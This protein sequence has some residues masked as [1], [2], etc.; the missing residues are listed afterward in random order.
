MN[1]DVINQVIMLT[2]MMM[3]GVIL[4][5]IKI[6]TDEVNKGLSNILLNVTLPSM[7]LYSFNFNFSMDML[8]SAAM[9]FLYSTLIHIVLII[10]SKIFYYKFEVSKKNVYTFATVF[11]NCGFVG[12]PV[13]QGIFGN[14]GVFYTSIFTIPFNIF[15]YSYGIMLF[16]GER[17]LK[18]IKKNLINMPLTSIFIGTII[19]L[20]SIKLPTPVIKTLGS[21]GNMTTPMSMFIIGAM[22]ADVKLKDVFKDFSLYYVNFIKLIAAPLIIYFALRLLGADKT[23]LYICVILVSM[24][25]ASLIGVLAER[26]NVNK[27]IASKCAFLT[28]ILSLITIP[29]I[30][31]LMDML[32]K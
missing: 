5:K 14:A 8:K 17:D 22:L 12:Y 11:S 9:V 10:L 31:A 3:A 1:I 16:T 18:S 29:S 21:I 27:A 25:T 2:L 28:T 32:T 19:F 23:L 20:F 7:I 15:V 26:Y 6:I 30:I 4:R 13:I 24:P